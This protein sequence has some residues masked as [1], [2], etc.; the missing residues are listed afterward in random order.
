MAEDG[1]EEIASLLQS[2]L[3][4]EEEVVREKRSR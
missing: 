2:L 1:P 3:T 4:E